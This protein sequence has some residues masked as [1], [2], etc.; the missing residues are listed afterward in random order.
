MLIPAWVICLDGVVVQIRI[1]SS[2]LTIYSPLIHFSRNSV[3]VSSG[4][5]TPGFS[6]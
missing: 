3:V 1:L 2:Y 4:F 5:L 6:I